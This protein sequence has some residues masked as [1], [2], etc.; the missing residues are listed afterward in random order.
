MTDKIHVVD[1]LRIC[2]CCC[3]WFCL[4]G[5]RFCGIGCWEN[6]KESTQTQQFH[7]STNKS[8]LKIE[9]SMCC[10]FRPNSSS[11]SALRIFFFFLKALPANDDYFFNVF[12]FNTVLNAIFST[13]CCCCFRVR[14]FLSLYFSLSHTLS[15]IFFSPSHRIFFLLKDLKYIRCI[16][17]KINY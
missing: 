10:S 7:S 17:H 2:I 6:T 1:I 12:K 4:F 13:I 9:L 16:Q 14:R 15:L 8:P 11:T 5:V 3:C